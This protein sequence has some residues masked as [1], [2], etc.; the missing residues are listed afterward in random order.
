MSVCT[1]STSQQSQHGRLM[2]AF[3]DLQTVFDMVIPPSPAVKDFLTMTAKIAESLN[4]R[5]ATL[6][7]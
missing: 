6:L 1:S 7:S 5:V 4:T 3:A 2:Q